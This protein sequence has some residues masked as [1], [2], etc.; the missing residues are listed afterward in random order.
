VLQTGVLFVGYLFSTASLWCL[1]ISDTIPIFN[2]LVPRSSGF[3]AGRKG[4]SV[5]PGNSEHRG[6]IRG[7]GN[8]ENR[9]F[10]AEV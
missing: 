6:E 8:T 1:F 2:N 9:R 10:N 7:R 4:W 5:L 3:Y